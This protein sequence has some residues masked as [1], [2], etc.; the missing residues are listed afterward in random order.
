MGPSSSRSTAAFAVGMTLLLS[1]SIANA[2][3]PAPSATTPRDPSGEALSSAEITWRELAARVPDLA[4]NGLGTKREAPTRVPRAS[5]LPSPQRF[6]RYER[7]TRSSVMRRRCY[8]AFELSRAQRQSQ[9][10]APMVV[11]GVRQ[12]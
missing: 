10:T 5:E 11:G 1:A 12:R 2:T 4:H 9:V 6:C 3:D 7:D 8:S